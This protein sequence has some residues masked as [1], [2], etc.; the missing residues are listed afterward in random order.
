MTPAKDPEPLRTQRGG[1]KSKA[2]R[3]VEKTWPCGQDLATFLHDT[4]G[5]SGPTW[6]HDVHGDSTDL[7]MAL[8]L[9]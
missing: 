9:L 1:R 6:T 3:D 2:R 4:L 5:A 7:A 8:A